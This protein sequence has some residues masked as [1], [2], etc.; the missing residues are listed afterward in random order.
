MQ[1]STITALCFASMAV[2]LPNARRQAYTPCDTG[3]YSSPECCAT[4]VLGV[5]DLDCA[6]RM[7]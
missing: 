7:L 1:F 5:A 4:D 3:L 2:A 6:A